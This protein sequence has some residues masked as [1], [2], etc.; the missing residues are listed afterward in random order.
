MS[1]HASI[2]P[3]ITSRDLGGDSGTNQLFLSSDSSD[4]DQDDDEMEVGTS[5]SV[6]TGTPS[7]N[8]SNNSN[9]ENKSKTNTSNRKRKERDATSRSATPTNWQ[10]LL[11]SKGTSKIFESKKEVNEMKKANLEMDL[12]MKNIRFIQELKN[13]PNNYSKEMSMALFPDLSDLINI[14]YKQ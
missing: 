9:I 3:K 4:E 11:S 8:N 2:Y 10:A 1:D 14:I 13:E 7:T 12:R 6:T 5:S